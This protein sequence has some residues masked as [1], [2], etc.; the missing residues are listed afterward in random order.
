MKK[1]NTNLTQV[2][3]RY[4]VSR[5][6]AQNW[7]N[8]GAPVHNDK[9]LDSWLANR[10]QV[11][12]AILREKKMPTFPQSGPKDPGVSGASSAL[13]RLEA[14]EVS[15]F[16]RMES[17]MEQGCDAVTIS[18]LRKNWLAISE[19][20]RKFDLL[21]EQNRREAGDLIPRE[22]F[23]DAISRFLHGVW[24]TFRL[25]HSATVPLLAM[26]TECCEVDKILDKALSTSWISGCLTMMPQ[27]DKG[28]ANLIKRKIQEG[29][30]LTD[31]ALKY[32]K[33]ILDRLVAGM[34]GEAGIVRPL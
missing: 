28:I 11:A 27:Q 9:L 17:A 18:E 19:S 10:R 25:Y 12:P 1:P 23:E 20:L 34:N 13:N 21:V 6:T 16:Q 14:S 22:I 5:T 7:K 4:N 8:K 3:K 32:R 31:E 29:F 15:A 30:T 33:E 26:H 24:I 2:A